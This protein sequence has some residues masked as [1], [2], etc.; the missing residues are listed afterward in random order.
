MTIWEIAIKFARAR[1]RPDDLP[2]SG[3]EALALFREAGLD[4]LP[5]TAEHAAAVDRLPPLHADPFDRM[6]IAQ[7]I[8]EP[9]RLV[10]S[11][12]ALKPYS[13]LVE[14]V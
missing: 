8:S 13:E 7:A 1:G 10:T 9:L 6:L 3:T 11:D 5:V 4:I 12:A 14:L 2:F